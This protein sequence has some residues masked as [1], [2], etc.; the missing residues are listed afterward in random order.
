LCPEFPL[1]ALFRIARPLLI[2]QSSFT[3]S[4]PRFSDL[5][6]CAAAIRRDL[7]RLADSS[8]RIHPSSE[9]LFRTVEY[10]HAA[11]ERVQRGID[12]WVRR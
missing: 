8:Q 5:A 7:E 12:R 6:G 4:N 3:V 11:W 10:D 1:I 2:W 9:N